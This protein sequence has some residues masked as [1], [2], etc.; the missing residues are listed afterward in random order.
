MTTKQAIFIMAVN[1]VVSLIISVSVFLILG[2][3][4]NPL[5]ESQVESRAP[6][7]SSSPT[8]AMGPGPAPSAERAVSTAETVTYVA[9]PGDSL[10]GIAE[11]FDVPVEDIMQANGIANPDFLRVGQELIIPIGGLPPATPTLSVSPTSTETPLPFEPPTPLP[12]ETRMSVPAVTA[13]PK[14]TVVT[15]TRQPQL[16]V[17]IKDVLAPGYLAREMV[18]IYNTGPQPIN[19]KDWTLSDVE[20]NVYTFPDILLWGNETSLRI[21][22]ASGEDTATDLYWN[23]EAA[24]WGKADKADNEATLKDDQGNIVDV[25]SYKASR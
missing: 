18:I 2:R 7:P 21:H 13:T 17:R 6:S 9:Q 10:S 22:T 1:A 14:P 19:L 25:Y 15:A 16:Q 5:V 4:A 11:K 20:G 24:T 8:G 23:R 12:S 3:P